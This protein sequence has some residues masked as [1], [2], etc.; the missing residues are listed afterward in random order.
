MSAAASWWVTT[1]TSTLNNSQ[2]GL[3][4]IKDLFSAKLGAIIFLVACFVGVYLILKSG[5]EK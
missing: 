2:S 3:T 4:I 5:L 1:T